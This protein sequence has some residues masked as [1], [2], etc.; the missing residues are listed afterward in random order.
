MT[1]SPTNIQ[2]G[3]NI[4]TQDN[5]ANNSVPVTNAPQQSGANNV[6][7]VVERTLRAVSQDGLAIR[8]VLE[9]FQ[10]DEAIRKAGGKA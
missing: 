4:Q 7:D 8:F 6:S 10:N 5:I 3:K 2:P 1:V 9:N